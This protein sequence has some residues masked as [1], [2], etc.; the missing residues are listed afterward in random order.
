LIEPVRKEKLTDLVVLS[1]I[2]GVGPRRIYQLVGIFGSL[3]AILAASIRD[4]MEVPG[5]GKDI[6][7][8]IKREQKPGEARKIVENALTKGWKVFLF[9]DVDYPAP[10]SN[11]ADRPPYLF[12]L[13]D[14]C[15]SD[16]NAMAIVG[17]RSA[18][19][20]GRAFA[21]HLASELARHEVTVISGL[22]RGIDLAAHRGAVDAGGRT[23]AV[24]GSSLD[25]IYPPEARPIVTKILD[26]G[27][28]FSEY[29]P[30]TAPYPTNFPRRNRIIS[31]LSQGIVVIEAGLRSGALSTASHALSQNREIFAVPGSPS[32]TTSI[33]TNELIKSG[34]RLLT[35]LEDVFAELPRLKGTSKARS[36]P[37]ETSLTTTERSIIQLLSEEPEQVDNLSRKLTTPVP[38]LLPIL[39]ALELKGIIKEVSGKRFML[40]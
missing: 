26:S 35:S 21:G 37:D 14:Y 33:G 15:Q 39:L 7:F 10:L 12:Y 3:P 23:I 22:A 2:A 31:G 6:A 27:C 13:G 11:V 9:D 8:K 19:D 29:P 38:D 24:F 18:S 30:G 17:S 34:A 5:I 25:I 40:T 32:K 36:I 28:I 20:E 1:N 4:L 16:H